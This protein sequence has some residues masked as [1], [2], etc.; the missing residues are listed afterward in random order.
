MGGV[1]KGGSTVVVKLV[2]GIVSCTLTLI[3]LVVDLV[4]VDDVMIEA[5]DTDG[6]AVELLKETFAEV[7]SFVCENKLF[8]D[9]V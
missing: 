7:C 6:V 5:D 9:V 2:P 8:V 3:T 4:L 1:S